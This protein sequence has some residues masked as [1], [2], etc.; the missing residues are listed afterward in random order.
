MDV[1][2]IV[3]DRKDILAGIMASQSDYINSMAV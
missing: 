3:V 2:H 1:I